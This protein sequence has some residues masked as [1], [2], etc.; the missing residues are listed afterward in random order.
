MA[1][2]PYFVR[3]GRVRV[4]PGCESEFD[5][6]F[7][8]VVL[9]AQKGVPGVLRLYRMRTT[10]ADGVTEYVIQSIWR[11]AAELERYK[12]SPGAAFIVREVAHT[13]ESGSVDE[14][15]LLAV[16]EYDLF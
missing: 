4:K 12:A 6:L 2:G 8:R 16:D 7:E 9:P 10:G 14:Y 5:R 13:V 15:E 1:E 3:I 11:S